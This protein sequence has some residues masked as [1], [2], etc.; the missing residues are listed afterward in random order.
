MNRVTAIC[1]VCGKEFEKLERKRAYRR[2][3]KGVRGKQAVTCSDKCAK[4]YRYE[5]PNIMKRLQQT[6]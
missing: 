5:K 6:I 2:L 1:R 3:P 4:I